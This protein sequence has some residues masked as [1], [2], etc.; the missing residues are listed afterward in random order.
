MT[1]A[2]V[3]TFDIATQF[4][5]RVGVQRRGVSSDPTHGMLQTRQVMVSVSKAGAEASRRVW[6]LNVQDGKTSDWNRMVELWDS[7]GGGCEVLTF[8]FRGTDANGETSETVQGRFMEAP[9]ALTST[10][11]TTHSW[12][13]RVEEFSHAP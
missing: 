1:H 9:L 11:I 13:A 8:T 2:S 7:T 12:S 10:G 5:A 6:T 3:D 4:P